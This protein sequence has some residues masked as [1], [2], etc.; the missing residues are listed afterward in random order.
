MRESIVLTVFNKEELVLLNTLHGLAK[1]KD[2]DV[3]VIVVDDGSTVDYARVRSLYEDVLGATWFRCETLLDLP[4]CYQIE[5][6]KNPAHAQNLGL[7]RATGDRLFLLSS[8]VILPPGTIAL[9]RERDLSRT[10]WSPGVVDLDTG[11]AF[12][13]FE[14]AYAAAWFIGTERRHWETIGPEYVDEQYMLGQAFDDNDLLARLCLAAGRLTIDCGL[15]AWHQSHPQFAY[16]DDLVGFE[17]S[18]AYAYAK[19]GFWPWAKDCG[20]QKKVSRVGNTLFIEVR[21]GRDPVASE[22]GVLRSV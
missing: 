10:I 21:V 1:N 5:G 16:S 7:A 11:A 17:R 14:R 6:H 22:R 3:E 4:D 9:T 19:W 8:D 15:K 20:L 18:K 2:Q 12:C 13:G